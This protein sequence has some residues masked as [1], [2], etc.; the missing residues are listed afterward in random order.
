MHTSARSNL[1]VIIIIK[2]NQI[3][4]RQGIINIAATTQTVTWPGPVAVVFSRGSAI[5]VLHGHLHASLRMQLLFEISVKG[6]GRGGRREGGRREGRGKGR[7]GSM[8]EG[9]RKG[10]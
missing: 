9:R 4:I 3:P 5:V 1:D 6:E 8:E 2:F 7:E 10:R